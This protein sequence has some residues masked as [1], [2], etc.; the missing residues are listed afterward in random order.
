MAS[1]YFGIN[2]WPAALSL[3]VTCNKPWFR[4]RSQ[5]GHWWGTRT[6]ALGGG[7]PLPLYTVPVLVDLI[8]PLDGGLLVKVDA[9]PLCV[10]LEAFCNIWDTITNRP[11][12]VRSTGTREWVEIRN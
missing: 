1:A 9:V 2:L 12:L 4:S 7:P 10:I 8:C 3:K 5:N 6:W 11:D